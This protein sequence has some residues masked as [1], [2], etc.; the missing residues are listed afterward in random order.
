MNEPRHTRK[1][2]CIT[3]YTI[4]TSPITHDEWGSSYSIYAQHD[5][6]LSHTINE[7]SHKL[8]VH[9]TNEPSHTRWMSRVT[10]YFNTLWTSLA[11]HDEWVVSHVM[12][13]Q[14]EREPRHTP[15]LM[16]RVWRG[17]FIYMCILCMYINICIYIYIYT[18]VCIYIYIL[19]MYIGM[20][21]PNKNKSCHR[22]WKSHVTHNEWVT[23]QIMNESHHTHVNQV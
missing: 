3:L 9:N 22:L 1:M 20:R 23:S 8:L 18:Y 12:H 5:R 7:S 19:W 15:W 14:Y 2:N 10:L 11:T 21:W 6:A 16:H 4:S 13:T 17:S